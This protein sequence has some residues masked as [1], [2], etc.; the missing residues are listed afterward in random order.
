MHKK[1]HTHRLNAKQHTHFLKEERHDPVTGDSFFEGEEVVFCAVCGSAFHA[2]SWAYMGNTHCDQQDTLVY[3]PKPP[4][5]RLSLRRRKAFGQNIKRPSWKKRLKAFGIDLACAA[6]LETLFPM[7]GAI[8]MMLRDV[9]NFSPGKFFTK[10]RMT[11]KKEYPI[12]FLPIDIA[13]SG[14]R[15]F[16]LLLT[17]FLLF[18]WSPTAPLEIALYFAASLVALA[19]NV[20]EAA[21][22]LNGETR[23]LDLMQETDVVE[24]GTQNLE[25]EEENRI[26]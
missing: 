3:F 7:S 21:T 20:M 26:L 9:R 18:M 14:L 16:P 6:A 5:R 22:V 4:K 12:Q 17:Y 10:L 23:I 24:T 11:A 15:N 19:L 1:V 25:I 13:R 8:F 2:E